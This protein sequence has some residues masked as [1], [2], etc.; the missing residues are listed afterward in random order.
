[1][2]TVRKPIAMVLAVTAFS[3]LAACA[4]AAPPAGNAGGPSSVSGLFTPACGGGPGGM[5]GGPGGGM[6]GGGGHGFGMGMMAGY[7]DPA[8]LDA[9]KSQ[10]GIRVDQDAA[11]TGY[12][13]ALDTARTNMQAFRQQGG[14]MR[15]ASPEDRQSFMEQMRA[16][17]L[18]AS[19]QVADAGRTLFAA[20]DDTQKAKAQQSLPG[21]GGACSQGGMMGCGAF[22]TP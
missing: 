9:V 11:W 6:M 19:Q 7:D 12:V 13:T 15:G 5:A 4:D 21:F 3:L 8:R 22:S 14:A 18:A 2:K 16:Q 20:L 17:R 1:M 10:L